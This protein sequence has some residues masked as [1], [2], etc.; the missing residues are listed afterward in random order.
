MDI[1]NGALGSH[2]DADDLS[3]EELLKAQELAAELAEARKRVAQA[4][5]HM[6]V[7]NHAMGLYELAAIHLSQ[8]PPH[9]E[10]AKLAIDATSAIIEKCGAR[11]GE[12]LET[13]EAARAQIQMQYVQRSSAESTTD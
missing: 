5:A 3:P 8:D 13:L 2:I 1:D 12:H 11:L 9:L 4:P 7:S 6:V 10:D